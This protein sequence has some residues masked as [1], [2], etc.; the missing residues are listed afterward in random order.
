MGQAIEN[1]K[2]SYCRKNITHNLLMANSDLRRSFIPIV[3][4]RRQEQL[5][6]AF[7]LLNRYRTGLKPGE[8][9]PSGSYYPIVIPNIKDCFQFEM[10]L[11]L[12]TFFTISEIMIK[13][14]DTRGWY[15]F[16]L[17]GGIIYRWC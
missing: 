1:M 2:G 11:S 12:L 10:F 17:S 16:R 5:P 8:E 13:T 9:L 7:L 3:V 14:D 4:Y 6:G 15:H